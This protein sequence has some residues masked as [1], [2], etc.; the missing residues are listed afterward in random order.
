MLFSLKKNQ[1]ED[2]YA[3]VLQDKSIYQAESYVQKNYKKTKHTDTQFFK[4]CIRNQF[5]VCISSS[6]SADAI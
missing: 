3:Q 6:K 4:V 2:V 1:A 5:Q